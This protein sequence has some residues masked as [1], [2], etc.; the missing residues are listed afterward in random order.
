M[1]FD[2]KKYIKEYF[3]KNKE[4]IKIQK[5]QYYLKNRT[6]F[7][8]KQKEYN[9]RN[10]KFISNYYSKWWDKHKEEYN[11]KHSIYNKQYRKNNVQALI[12]HRLRANLR[13][14]LYLKRGNKYNIDYNSI[15][16]YLKPFPK[17]IEDYHIDHI[18]PLSSF[19]LTK[20]EEIQ[21]A[22][23][24]SNHQWLLAHDNLI[25]SNKVIENVN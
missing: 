25:K 17:N 23:T 3:Q 22:F 18:I 15:L 9:K 1:S 14:R 8:N 19:N 13:K 21:K 2:K 12:K 11:K 4:K 5:K 16:N 6:K 7:L 20:D 24:P 10:K